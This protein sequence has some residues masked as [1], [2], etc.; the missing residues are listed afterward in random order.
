MRFFDQGAAEAGLALGLS[1]GSAGRECVAL[2]L[3]GKSAWAW[4]QADYF[5]AQAWAEESLQ[6][7]REIGNRFGICEALTWSGMALM[8]LGEHQ[9]AR[10]CLEESLSLA[11]KA[12]DGNEIAF[13][14]WQLGQVAM[15][16]ENYVQ[17]TILLQEALT[18]YKSLKQSGG[19][20]FLLG[21]LGK[22]SLQQND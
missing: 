5:H 2:V 12:H 14:V 21:D 1:L 22:A 6:L 3:L 8:Q 16:Q 18:V 11:R 19:I 9:Q 7:F 20:I 4:Y 13:A 10:I 15:L 17:A